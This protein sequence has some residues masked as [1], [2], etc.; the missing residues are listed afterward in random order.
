MKNTKLVN[1]VYEP[2]LDEIRVKTELRDATDHFSVTIYKDKRKEIDLS[3]GDILI[4]NV[5]GKE[6]IRKLT[7][8][9]HITLPKK[10]LE[11]KRHGDE[12]NII[13]KK[14][15]K[16]SYWS[17]RPQTITY[18]SKLD[19]RYFIPKETVTG[20]PLY[21]IPRSKNCSTVG[22]TRWGPVQQIELQNFVDID[23]I[24]E[25]AGF[26]FGDGTTCE[27]IRSFR[28]T[29][30]E[31]SVL[32]YCLE[33]LESMG[34]ERRLCKVQVIYSTNKE[35]LSEDIKQRCIDFWSKILCL[36]KSKIISVTKSKNVRETK[37]Y[38]SARISID[39]SVL[40]EV[41]LHGVLKNIVK[42]IRDPQEKID[43]RLLRGFIR[44]LLAAE[45]SVGLNKHK[46]VVR[47]GIAFDPHSDELDIYK[48]LLQNLDIT[49]NHIKDNEIVIQKYRN[50]I[51]FMKI[52]AFKMHDLRNEK[53][54]EG[55]KNH[56]FFKSLYL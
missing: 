40:V 38:G 9:Y 2:D 3:V 26:Y 32:N 20:F 29:N 44:G 24:A 55:F 25:L 54:Q 35:I 15:L 37:K 48:D 36:E 39:R 4:V 51:E 22:Y 1:D 41:F 52:N 28:L 18:H 12:V 10:I 30:C 42:R 47:V 17:R 6:I 34:I 23:K 27:G 7:K 50:M 5:N 21:V 31:P 49:Y 16:E 33:I 56:K 53:F 19:L 46:S 45:G 11:G 13:I 43:Y 14:N 8:S